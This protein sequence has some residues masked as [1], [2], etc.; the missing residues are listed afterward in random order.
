MREF[1]AE[2]RRFF[3][4]CLP[5]EVLARRGARALAYG[6][7]RPVGLYDP[8]TGRRPFAVVQLRQDNAAATLYNLVGFQT[9]LR[10]GEQD[11]VFRL[12]PGLEKAEFVR[13]GQMHR[14]TFLDSPRLLGPD[15][16][17]RNRPGLF[18]AGQLS[19]TEGYVGST[20]SGWVA[21]TNAARVAAGAQ[22]VAFPATTMLGALSHYVSND[23]VTDFQPMKPNFGLL[24]PLAERHKRR[25]RYGAYSERALEALDQFIVQEDLLPKGATA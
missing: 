23:A 16:Q 12:I 24:P 3:E 6:P 7:L 4:A 13:Y 25:E 9:N 10:Y 22:T 17:V 1:E 20:A 11:R 8:R 14:N 21:G 19:G 15:F 18:V 5:V 2:D